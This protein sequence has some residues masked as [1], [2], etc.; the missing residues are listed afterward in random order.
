MWRLTDIDSVQ[1]SLSQVCQLTLEERRGYLTLL[2]VTASP[3]VRLLLRRPDG[4]TD[5]LASIRNLSGPGKER[6]T[7]YRRQLS[8][9]GTFQNTSR[10]ESPTPR[11]APISKVSSEQEQCGRVSLL[12][13]RKAVQLAQTEAAV[14]QA[15]REP[16]RVWRPGQG[17]N[18]PGASTP[19]QPQRQA[20]AKPSN[21]LV[22]CD[23]VIHILHMVHSAVFIV[24]IYLC[25]FLYK[26]DNIHK[27][28]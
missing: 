21:V 11:A 19:G 18:I 10:G 15:G 7:S 24:H 1:V 25:I 20:E 5:W 22:V 3:T 13:H 26:C 12:L 2:L 27:N 16:L 14:I 23:S 8:E 28:Y 9:Y 6:D 4:L 17:R